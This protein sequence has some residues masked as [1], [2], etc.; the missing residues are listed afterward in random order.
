VALFLD[1]TTCPRS[2]L[3]AGRRRND[4]LALSG[5]G[6]GGLF[7]AGALRPG[8]FIAAGARRR[9]DPIT[10][11]NLTATASAQL[12][13]Q[14]SRSRATNTVALGADFFRAALTTKHTPAQSDHEIIPLYHVWRRWPLP[15]GLI[16]AGG[17]AMANI[18]RAKSTFLAAAAG[19]TLAGLLASVCVVTAL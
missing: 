4:V 7:L 17:T 1:L 5:P 9:F 18:R 11:P 13:L 19:A 14:G 16:G 10:S 12:L 2:S 3:L 8:G 6:S 15:N